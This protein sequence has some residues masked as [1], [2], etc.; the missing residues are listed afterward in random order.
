METSVSLLER[1]AGAPTEDRR[2]LVRQTGKLCPPFLSSPLQY[3]GRSNP[4]GERE[5]SRKE[6][7]RMDI[8]LTVP[9]ELATR[10][11]TVEHELPQILELGI[12]E[13]Q[14][15][16][17]TGFSG[18]VG[19]LETLASLPT[20]EE[21]LALRPSSSLEERIEEL[22]DKNRTGGLSPEEQ[23]EWEAYQYVEHLVRLAKTR[24]ALKLKSA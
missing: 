19:V 23:R 9:D 13:W 2:S 10:L 7:G 5:H 22:L 11:R 24:A 20:P 12:R 16:G 17:E 1:L 14:A 6:G 21:V 4:R 15:R 18:M 3:R 8:T